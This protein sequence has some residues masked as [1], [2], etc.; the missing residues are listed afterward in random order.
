MRGKGSGLEQ[1]NNIRVTLATCRCFV[2]ENDRRREIF[3]MISFV[4]EFLLRMMHH[5]GDEMKE[6]ESSSSY[7]S[8]L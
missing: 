8:R 7:I 1:C 4:I 5:W 2:E 6:S 3:V